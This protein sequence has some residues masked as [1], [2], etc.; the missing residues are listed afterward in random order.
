MPYLITLVW[1]VLLGQVVGFLGSALSSMTYDF[2]L[3]T[4]FSLIVGCFV[5]L[6][7]TICNP[8]KEET[9]D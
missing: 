1:S 2:T 9:H 4:I 8:K 3:T 6:I 7:G 5:I